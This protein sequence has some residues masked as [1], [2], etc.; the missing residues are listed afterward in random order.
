MR[1]FFQS[2]TPGPDGLLRLEGAEAHHAAKVIRLLAGE[3]AVVL[4]G[5]GLEYFCTAIDVDR[6]TVLLRVD[7]EKAH[8][9]PKGQIK[10]VQAVT[11]GKSFDFILQKS[12]ELGAAQIVPL[13]SDRVVA[14]PKQNDFANKVAKWNQVAIEAIKQCGA[15]W[16]PEITLPKTVDEALAEDIGSELKFVAALVAQARHPRSCFETFCTDHGRTPNALSVWIGPEGDFSEAEYSQLIGHGVM[17]VNFGD[18]VL[19]SETAAVYALSVFG[20]ELSAQS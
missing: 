9:K 16:L 14:R 3:S 18:R 19:R 17:P 8:P 20:Y 11:K 2:S 13:L 1:H 12:V 7:K 10:L 5:R 6:K 4:N 15:P